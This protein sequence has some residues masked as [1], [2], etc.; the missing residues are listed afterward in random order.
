MPTNPSPKKPAPQDWH[1]AD[2][3][4]ALWKRRM[5]LRRLSRLNDYSHSVLG[6]AMHRPWP[7]AEKII[8]DFLGVTPQAIWPSRYNADGTP[9]TGAADRQKSPARTAA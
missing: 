8:A 2:I 5:S 3:M 9:K 7:K 1:P 4:A 6:I